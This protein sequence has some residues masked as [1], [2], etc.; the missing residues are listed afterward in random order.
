[1]TVI[2]YSDE[3]TS[4]KI[5]QL[6]EQVA[7]AEALARKLGSDRFR[8]RDAASRELSDM[9]R[10]ALTVV[11]KTLAD[12]KREVGTDARK[13]SPAQAA[14]ALESL[15]PGA[16]PVPETRAREELAVK[17]ASAKTREEILAI[18]KAIKQSP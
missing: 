1:M 10:L 17:L 5:N 6:N 16:A 9:G 12:L 3:A 11:E 18:K 15:D 7:K 14:K 13:L 2:P 8:E 4:Q